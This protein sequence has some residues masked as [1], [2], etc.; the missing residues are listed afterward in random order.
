MLPPAGVAGRAGRKNEEEGYRVVGR[1]EGRQAG[2]SLEPVMHE[3]EGIGEVGGNVI[4][5]NAKQPPIEKAE[6]TAALP[7]SCSPAQPA[8]RCQG[9]VQHAH[10]EWAAGQ[11]PCHRRRGR[12]WSWLRPSHNNVPSCRLPI[13]VA[14][15]RHAARLLFPKCLPSFLPSFLS[16]LMSF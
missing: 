14:H 1:V 16:S 15:A 9:I 3:G 4:E 7:S 11:Q 13:H 5:K 10:V 8:Y 12:I 2:A 6:N